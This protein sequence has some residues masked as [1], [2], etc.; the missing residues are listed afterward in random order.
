MGIAC[1]LLLLVGLLLV[2][3][4]WVPC[5]AQLLRLARL[6][7]R[8]A[9]LSSSHRARTACPLPR[10]CNNIMAWVGDA[11]MYTLVTEE[12]GAKLGYIAVGTLR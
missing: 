8:H 3:R 5:R 4:V 1:G 2:S 10:R 12:V 9:A 6:S 7:G 11:A